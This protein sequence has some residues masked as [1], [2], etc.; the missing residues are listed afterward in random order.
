M[1]FP[2]GDQPGWMRGLIWRPDKWSAVVAVLAGCA[3]VL[4]QI[5]RVESAELADW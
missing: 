4:P 1:R 3:G 5:G 2:P